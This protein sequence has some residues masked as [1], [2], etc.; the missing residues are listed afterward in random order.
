MR[1]SE[2][3]IQAALLHPE[4][5]VRVTAAAY[6]SGSYSRSEAVMPPVIQ[7]VERYG[8]NKA[9]RILRSAERLPQTTATVDWLIDELRR[10]YDLQQRDEDNYRYAIALIL[11]RAGAELLRSRCGDIIALPMFPEPLRCP[12]DERLERLEWDWDRSY[13]A[14]EA[15]AGDTLRTGRLT[16]RDARRAGCIIESL[17]RHGA[18]KAATVL[19]LWQRSHAAGSEAWLRW[20]RPWIINLAG[21]M[22]LDAAVP[23]AVT[24]LCDDDLNVAD[25]STTALIRIGSNRVVRAI[26]ECWPGA[27]ANFRAAASDVLEHVH[28]DLCAETGLQFFIAEEVRETKLFLAHAVLSQFLAEGVEPI[29]Q[30]VLAHGAEVPPN[31]LDIRRRLAAACT[32]MGVS[33]PE[34]EAWYAEAVADNWGLGNYQPHR[35]ADGF[36]PDPPEPQR[37]GNGQSR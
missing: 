35:L 12:F 15:L 32:V 13:A 31:G 26:A 21:A 8:R 20:C 5:E 16:A 30:L 27:D 19:D 37:S 23:I 28:T 18:A 29:R 9:F 34:F 3:A 33:F 6:F 1:L 17:A 2:S 24:H 11:Y 36:P 10:P 4:E 22:R 14:L 25:E 7:A